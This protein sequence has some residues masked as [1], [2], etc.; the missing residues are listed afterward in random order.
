MFKFESFE[1]K[2]EL[3]SLFVVTLCALPQSVRAQDGNNNMRIFDQERHAAGRFAAAKAIRKPLFNTTGELKA[4]GYGLTNYGEAGYQSAGAQN[5]RKFAGS[6]PAGSPVTPYILRT[7][8]TPGGGHTGGGSGDGGGGED[9]GT[10]GTGSPFGGLDGSDNPYGNPDPVGGG[11][12]INQGG[13][14]DSNSDNY[15]TD[16]G[17]DN[18]GDDGSADPSLRPQPGSPV[19]RIPRPPVGG[20]HHGNPTWLMRHWLH[21]KSTS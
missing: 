11:E 14:D 7:K 1:H 8:L 21:P 20:Q 13:S 4:T 5:A 2:L 12:P 17:G 15:P 6:I 10:D 9:Q 16:H 19:D 18:A 3:L